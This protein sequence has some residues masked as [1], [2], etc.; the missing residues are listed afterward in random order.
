M[1]DQSLTLGG[2]GFHNEGELTG[3]LADGSASETAYRAVLS[4]NVRPHVTVRT[5]GYVQHQRD[6]QDL[7][8]YIQIPVKPFVGARVDM[9]DHDG[10]TAS[11]ARIMWTSW[12]APSLTVACSSRDSP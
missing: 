3:E 7:T 12:P 4:W 8:E 2:S 10:A 1:L 9:I 5:G 6:R 11:Q